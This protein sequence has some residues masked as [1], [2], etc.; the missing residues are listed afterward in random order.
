MKVLHLLASN[1]YS[2]AE[3]VV[4]QIIN[5]FNGEVEMAYCSP[6]GEIES[7]LKDKEIRYLP[8]KEFCG[9]DLQVAVD[10]FKPDIIHAHDVRASILASKFHKQ[11]KIISH[12]HG[13]DKR[14]MGRLTPKSILY[15]LSTRKYSKIFWVSNSC[16]DDYFFKAFVKK[17]SKVLHNIINIENLYSIAQ[18]DKNDYNFD[19]CYLGRLAEIKNP[20]RALEIMKQVIENNKEIKC[21]VVGDGDLRNQSEEFI[22]SNKLENNIKLFGFVKNPYKI[23]QNSKVLLM[24][25]INE[26]TPMALLEAFSLGVPLVST[27]VDGAVELIN[28][29]KMGYL[30]E[31]NSEAVD[32]ILKILNSNQKEIKDYLMKFSKEYNDIEKYKNEILNAYKKEK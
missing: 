16:V 30:Y 7:T 31:E 22:K 25:S 28:D 14:N 5:M 6:I 12:I 20:M 23:L 2:G 29:E 8:L 21:A 19:I 17:K 32:H 4:C 9:K 27:K 18:Q 15:Q 13:N 10:E 11:C 24:S 1:K 26:G 3:N